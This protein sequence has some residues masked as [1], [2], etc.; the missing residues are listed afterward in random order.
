[1]VNKVFHKQLCRNTEA[2]I[3][4]MVVKS[5]SVA[6]HLQDLAK[7]FSVMAVVNMKLNPTKSFFGRQIFEVHS[8]RAGH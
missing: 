2:Y 5:S 3:D 8:I 6:N 7:A 1:M 4:D